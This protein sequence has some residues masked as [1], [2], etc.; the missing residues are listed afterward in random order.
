MLIR[1]D[2]A[3]APYFFNLQE[4]RCFRHWQTKALQD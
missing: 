1:Q 4:F 2:G 3:S